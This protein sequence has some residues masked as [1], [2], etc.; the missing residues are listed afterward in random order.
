[1]RFSPLDPEMFRMPAGVALSHLFARRFDMASFWAEQSFRE[2]PDLLGCRCH[3]R[4]K[5]RDRRPNWASAECRRIFAEAGFHVSYLR[6]RRLDSDPAAG[7]SRPIHDRPADGRATGVTSLRSLSH[8]D[9]EQFCSSLSHPE[10]RRVRIVFVRVAKFPDFQAEYE[11]RFP[12]PAA[13]FQSF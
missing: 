7:A 6:S 8:S 1:M 11:G 9:N 12:S 3:R 13:A 5:S 10:G 2:A 4:R